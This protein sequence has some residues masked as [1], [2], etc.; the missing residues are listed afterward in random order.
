[1]LLK[2][3][4]Q[5]KWLAVFLAGSAAAVALYAW[6]ARDTPDGLSGG[7]RVGLLY[8][9]AGGLLIVY[10]W[11]L[12]ALRSVPSWWWLGSRAFWLKG[13]VWLGSLSFVLILCHS[14]GRFGGM[15]ER[16]LYTVFA[17]VVVTGFYGLALQQ[18]L[19][20]LLT[21]RVASEV[22]YEQ[23]PHLC[24]RL[25]EE[26]D[27]LVKQTDLAALP[28]ASQ[29]HLAEL[30]EDVVRPYLA[31]P[32]RSA[33]LADPV[34]AGEV[35]ARARALPG[36]PAAEP[37]LTGLETFTAERRLLAEQERLQRWLHGWLYV[38]VPLSA[39]MMA[40]LAAHVV[41]TLYY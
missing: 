31:Y 33:T 30:Y 27:R 35:F 4:R 7:S 26:A 29:K 25:R 3:P 34:K 17:L 38:H 41:M 9:L 24:G 22:P 15:V 6:L 20:R 18:A 12:S 13:H 39:A 2:D 36:S 37:L 40:L 23:I 16:I 28:E 32:A 5:K 14:G 19:P 11:L 8:G 1:L 10:A 21:R